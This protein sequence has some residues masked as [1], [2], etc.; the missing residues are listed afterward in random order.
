MKPLLLLVDDE[1]HIRAF[2]RKS[3]GDRLRVVEA[4]N[5]EEALLQIQRDP[6]DIVVMDLEMPVMD[7]LVAATEMRKLPVMKDKPIMALTGYDDDQIVAKLRKAG[8]TFYVR[9]EGDAREF[10]KKVLEF[11]GVLDGGT[12]E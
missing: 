11:A 10:V 12:D 6:P 8:F 5:G 3:V 1:P 2:L 9:K 7:G 4:N